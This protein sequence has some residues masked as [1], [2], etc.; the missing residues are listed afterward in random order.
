[1]PKKLPASYAKKQKLAAAF[2][3]QREALAAECQKD[4]D[5]GMSLRKVAD[6][7]NGQ[8]I[9]T[10]TGL[11]WGQAN[12]AQLIRN[13]KPPVVKPK[14]KAAVTR[15]RRATKGT[16]RR[17]DASLARV[18]A[19]HPEFEEWRVLCVQWL[20][21]KE[22]GLAHALMGINAFIDYLVKYKLPVRPAEFLLSRTAMPDLYATTWGKKRT[23]GK[24]LLHNVAHFFLEWV[25]VQPDFCEEDDFGRLQTAYST[26]REQP[27]HG[28]VN[29]DS[30]AK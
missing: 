16:R 24:V 17:T 14:S 3:A 12:I 15:E 13:P 11:P 26:Q 1:M 29:R 28:K 4:L 9:R 23:R 22:S 2:D 8:G 30:T 7:L 5:S 27:F 19:D 6:K 21:G 18:A 20:K 25:L 10:K